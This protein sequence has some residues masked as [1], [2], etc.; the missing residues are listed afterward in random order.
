MINVQ[1]FCDLSMVKLHDP[2]DIEEHSGYHH[3]IT[4]GASAHTAFRTD[5]GLERF[6]ERTG[7]R[8]KFLEKLEKVDS[9]VLEGCYE[10]ISL[11]GAADDLDELG[12]LLDLKETKIIDNGRITKAFYGRGSIDN[13][14]NKIF[15]LNPNYPRKEYPWEAWHE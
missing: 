8:K 4:D 10:R 1:R 7:L 14:G 13:S 11:A 6:L 12:R 9:Y 2:K 3:L 15:Y 5:Q